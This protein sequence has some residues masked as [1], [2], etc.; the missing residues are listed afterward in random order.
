MT[1][2]SSEKQFY[3]EQNAPQWSTGRYTQTALSCRTHVPISTP[4]PRN[5]AVR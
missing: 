1:T 3:C 4:I 5:P 2:L